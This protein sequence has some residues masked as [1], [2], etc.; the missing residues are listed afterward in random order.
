MVW[1]LALPSE[2]ADGGALTQCSPPEGATRSAES[3]VSSRYCRQ[4]C[5]YS[6]PRATK[7]RRS[8]SIAAA[9]AGLTKGRGL[10][11]LQRQG[12]AVACASSD[13]A[14]QLYAEIFAE[15]RSSGEGPAEAAR[16]VRRLVCG[17]G[18]GESGAAG[19]ADTRLPAGDGQ[20]GEI[21]A[22]LKRMYDRYH[23][24]MARITRE[25]SS[26]AVRQHGCGAGSGPRCWLRSP[27][28][29]CSSG[30]AFHMRVDGGRSPRAPKRRFLVG[31]GVTAQ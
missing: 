29:C 24:E 6:S 21:A 13:D 4:H 28:V 10:L 22:H 11:L 17:D 12:G 2:R 27:T 8:T 20:R 30:I 3:T 23:D 31:L 18:R 25:G 5:S 15:L 19:A 16:D 7:T 26:R 1:L 9:E 14:E